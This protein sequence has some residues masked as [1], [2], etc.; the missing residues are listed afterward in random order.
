LELDSF[1]VRF[2]Q[3]ADRLD[4]GKIDE[5][6]FVEQN[7]RLLAQ[8]QTIQHRLAILDNELGEQRQYDE[9]WQQEHIMM[10]PDI[11]IQ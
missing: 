2:N 3:W 8:K 6:Q 7:Q 1:S 10:L 5:E 11:L 4:S 9:R